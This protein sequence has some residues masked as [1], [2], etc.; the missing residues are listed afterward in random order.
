MTSIT[1][2]FNDEGGLHLDD[3]VGLPFR[4]TIA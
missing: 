1:I 2:E 3:D 4:T